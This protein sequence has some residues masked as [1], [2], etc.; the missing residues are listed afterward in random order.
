MRTLLVAILLVGCGPSD[1]RSGGDGGPHPDSAGP[2]ADSDGDGY[3]TLEGDCNDSDP[4]IHPGQAELCDGLDNDCNG[5]V[6]DPFDMDMDGHSTCLGDCD[7]HDPTTYPMAPEL[8]DGKD[9]D[10]DG[11]VDNH[12]ADYDDD[13]DGYTEAQ[14]DC[15][16]TNPFV[17]PGAVEVQTK[18][19][20]TAEG[21]DNNCNGMID[22]PNPPCD[23][24]LDPADPLSYPKAMEL[25]GPWVT[26][27]TISAASSAQARTIVST[28]GSTYAPHTGASMAVL[29]TGNVGG[30]APQ[31]PQPGTAFTNTAPHPDP[32]G[33][34]PTGCGSADPFTVNDLVELDYDITA[35]TNAKAFSY[36]FNFVSAEYPEWVCTQFDDTFIAYL[37]SS[38]YTGN[39]SFDSMGR[40][41]SIN[42]GF[43]TVCPPGSEPPGTPPGSCMGSSELAGTGFEGTVGGGTG[44]LTTTAPVAP[45]EHITL[46]FII[47]DEG[48]HIYDSTVLLDNFRWL[49]DPV[50][51]PV[52]VG[53]AVPPS[54]APAPAPFATP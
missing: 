40:V 4:N 49:A 19:D 14:G 48:D 43:F 16:D 20:G 27:A 52:T 33:A 46:R 22:E 34:P 54:A 35:P 18:A 6:D 5:H 7:D 1:A 41:V 26:S 39:I 25:C 38:M 28:F 23:T 10:C 21:V 24:G 51:G 31:N 30:G 32:H 12:T 53:R 45:G 17:N 50:D 29:S 3:S 2:G 44:W 13:G 9:N 37:N 36:D 15:D 8:A 42:V 11:I 47:W